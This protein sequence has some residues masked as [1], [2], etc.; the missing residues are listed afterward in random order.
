MSSSSN[1]SIQWYYSNI[2]INGAT[3]KTYKTSKFGVYKLRVDS[4]NGCS[5]FSDDYDLM[6]TSFNEINFNKKVSIYPNPTKGLFNIE[7]QLAFNYTVYDYNG[8]EIITGYKDVYSQIFDLT[9][10]K[11]GIYLLKL[12]NENEE[13]TYKIIKD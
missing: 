3:N 9:N 1:N 7:S 11:N 2:E 8:K 10:F 12:Y 6:Y 4:A 13:F 5:N